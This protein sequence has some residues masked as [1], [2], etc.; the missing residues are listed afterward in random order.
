MVTVHLMLVMI[1]G[2]DQLSSAV[3]LSHTMEGESQFTE[4]IPAGDRQA[5][6]RVLVSAPCFPV[7]VGMSP[8]PY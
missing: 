6:S 4:K 2:P 3:R 5:P 8:V 7:E 1:G